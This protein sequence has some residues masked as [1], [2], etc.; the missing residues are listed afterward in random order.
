VS[1]LPESVPISGRAEAV[2]VVNTAAL[3]IQAVVVPSAT[4]A[5]VLT[6]ATTNPP[7]ETVPDPAV[8]TLIDASNPAVAAAIA[9]YHINDVGFDGEWPRNTGLQPPEVNYSEIQPVVQVHPVKLDLSA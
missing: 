5:A 2:P 6:A 9:A 1:I 3:T 4:Q 8:N 7:V